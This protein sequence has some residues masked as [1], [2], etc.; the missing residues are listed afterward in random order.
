[1]SLTRRQYLQALGLGSAG[2]L[3][4]PL[5]ALEKTRHLQ[6]IGLQLYTVRD[7]M[8]K[9]VAATLAAI[10]QAGYVEVETAGTGNLSPAQ[11]VAALQDNNLTAPAAH[12]PFDL[13]AA[14]PE[15]IL[16]AAETIGYQFIVLPWIAPELRTL[17]G[18][19]QVI[20]VLNTFG[21]QCRGAGVQLC[22]HNHDFEFEALG[23]ERAFDVMLREC[24]AR[25]VQ[26]E[27][28]L[29]WATHAGVDARSYLQ[30]DPE[31]FPLCHVKDRTAAGEMVSVGK[32]VIDFA[33]MFAA[34]SGLQHYFVE[35]DRPEDSLASVQYSI[36][37]LQALRY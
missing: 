7:L 18:Y 14:S 31:R 34:G 36:K 26:F 17:A 6:R 3:A 25:L 28:D 2:V 37:T 10:A 13:M 5:L 16:E 4:A 35:H 32:G 15:A 19:S 21:E 30:A 11:F 22:Y 1:M 9:D 27:L 29:F 23:D 8:A 12:V 20:E 24:D 33:A